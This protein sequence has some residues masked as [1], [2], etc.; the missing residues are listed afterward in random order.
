MAPARISSSSI[1]TRIRL[2]KRKSS[3]GS[4]LRKVRAGWDARL[5]STGCAGSTSRHHCALGSCLALRLIPP[6]P[7][8]VQYGLC[9]HK[10]PLLTRA[11]VTPEPGEA[12]S[13]GSSSVSPEHRTAPAL[14]P[15]G[16]PQGALAEIA[17]GAATTKHG[18]A[19]I[20]IHHLK[21]GIIYVFCI[22]TVHIYIWNTYRQTDRHLFLHG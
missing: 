6:S 12:V 9:G 8:R 1:P 10:M 21:L 15:L 11:G 22:G 19:F 5:I 7:A 2:W 20:P 17:W 4:R 3:Q 16:F 18:V 13:R 14:L